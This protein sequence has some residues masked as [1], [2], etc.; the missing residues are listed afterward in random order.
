[1]A[2]PVFGDT[3]DSIRRRDRSRSPTAHPPTRSRSCARR[4]ARC[5]RSTARPRTWTSTA[6]PG[7]ERQGQPRPQAHDIVIKYSLDNG[8]HLERALNIDNTAAPVLRQR[9]PGAGRPA[10]ARPGHGA[11]NLLLT[12][13]RGLSGRLR[14]AERVQRRQQHH[15]DL[16][17]Q[18]LPG[19]EQ[20]FVVYPELFGITVPYSCQYA[21]RLV[22][23]STNKAV[24]YTSAWGGLPYKTDQL[25]SGIRDAKQDANRGNMYAYVINWQEDPLGLKL[26][27][28]EGRAAGASGANV[29][30]GTDVWYSLP[31]LINA[32]APAWIRRSSSAAPGAADAH[33]EEHLRQQD[34]DRHQPDHP[35]RRH[36]RP[37]QRRRLAAEHRP[38]RRPGG[39]RLRGNQGHDGLGRRQVCP[40]PQL[41]LH[42]SA[43]VRRAWLHHQRP[44]GECPPRPLPGA[45]R[46]DNEVPLLFIYKQGNFTQ[47]WRVR[48]H[49]APRRGRPHARSSAP[50]VDVGELLRPSIM[51]PTATRC[52]TSDLDEHGPAM[53]F[54]GTRFIGDHPS[55]A[56]ADDGRVHRYRRQ[57]AGERPGAS[58]HMRGSNILIGF[59]YVPDL[60]AFSL[61]RRP[62]AVPLHGAALDGWWRDLDG[63]ARPDANDGRR[64]PATRKEPRIVPTPGSG[65]S[66]ALIPRTART[67]TCSTSP[68]ACR[69]TCGTTKKPA[70]V[71]IYMLVTLR[72]RRELLRAQGHHGRRRA[73][74]RQ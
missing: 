16:E 29:N 14:Q 21:S 15:R 68:S 71:D 64:S 51:D 5:S 44:V 18:V 62:G 43:A 69:T 60:A 8:D 61:P 40:L 55:W 42:D 7:L 47:W 57:H 12:P 59:S 22:W 1:M 9:H 27:E 74:R 35:S 53:N 45:V 46:Q 20:R 23:N 65:P 36:V 70:D 48:H 34:F 6:T 73:V 3:M 52:T 26:G 39:D 63:R 19:G 2:G 56:P 37:G 33:H 24:Q 28:A 31:R 41:P 25:T 72:R 10:D 58:R 67:G 32:P 17:R 66:C 11:P 4:T 49:A 54:S 38:G 13:S 50:Q 30:N